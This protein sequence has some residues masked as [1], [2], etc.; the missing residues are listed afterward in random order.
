MSEPQRGRTLRSGLADED[1]AL[2][3]QALRQAAQRPDHLDTDL[4]DLTADDLN[5]LRDAV[6]DLYAADGLVVTEA[7]I[8]E[9]AL[10]RRCEDLI[11]RFAPWH[12]GK[13]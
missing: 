5:G 12:R 8:D 1:V 11:D 4:G 13:E 2:L 3:E 10:G 9:T 7:S 6:G